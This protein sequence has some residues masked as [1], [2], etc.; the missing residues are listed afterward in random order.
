MLTAYTRGW[1]VVDTV[2]KKV[3]L[4]RKIHTYADIMIL[5]GNNDNMVD[6]NMLSSKLLKV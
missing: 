4:N 2:V 6:Y 3:I 5:G 1:T